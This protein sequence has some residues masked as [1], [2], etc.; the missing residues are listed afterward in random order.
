MIL[1]LP[2]LYSLDWADSW[3]VVVSPHLLEAIKSQGPIALSI[4]IFST[5]YST[6]PNSGQTSSPT[7]SA[8]LCCLSSVPSTSDIIVW[9]VVVFLHRMAATQG[10]PLIRPFLIFSM[11]AIWAPQ[12]T[13]S[14][15]AI[16]S[17]GIRRLNK[18]NWELRR[19]DFGSWQMIQWRGRA[20][21]LSR[22]AEQQNGRMA[23]WQN[24]GMAEWWNGRNGYLPTSCM[25]HA[26]DADTL[27]IYSIDEDP[28]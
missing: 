20:K 23:E 2:R 27:I 11:G 8:R 17:P 28:I 5:L 13:Y 6:P 4:F 26:D 14:T 16:P 7:C 3:L 15:E 12:S 10:R 22:M 24:G 21:P 9:L 19:L 1:P 25:V 18:T